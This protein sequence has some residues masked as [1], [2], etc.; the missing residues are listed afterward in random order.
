MAAI[1]DH[2][3]N[4]FSVLGRFTV[5]FLLPVE[6]PPIHGRSAVFGHDVTAGYSARR[7]FLV[8][9]ATSLAVQ[10]AV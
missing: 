6:S 1:Y 3:R 10:I 5:M 4:S 2:A 8:Y 7:Q 9:R